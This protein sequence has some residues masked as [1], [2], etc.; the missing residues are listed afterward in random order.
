MSILIDL[1][2]KNKVLEQSEEIKLYLTNSDYKL[3]IFGTEQY[4]PECE[5]FKFVIF[6]YQNNLNIKAIHI[7]SNFP[8]KASILSDYAPKEA[9]LEGN[10]WFE[11]DLNLKK[12]V[13][14]CV[15]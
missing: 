7:V 6:L 3:K 9:F 8:K 4:T 10:G 15:S 13:S 14:K 1:L 11:L 5:K 12:C 2:D